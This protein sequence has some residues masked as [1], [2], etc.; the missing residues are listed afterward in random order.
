MKLSE[1]DIKE[2]PMP[3]WS[4]TGVVFR[5]YRLDGTPLYV[6]AETREELVRKLVEEGY[7]GKE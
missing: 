5:A 3:G 6:G 7:V 1:V 2:E 4:R